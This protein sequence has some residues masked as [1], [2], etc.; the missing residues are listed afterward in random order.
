[1]ISGDAHMLG[2]DDG[3]NNF[4]GEFPVFQVGSLDS[5]PSCKGGPYSHGVY[6]GK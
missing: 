1:M 3:R 2:F 5:I 4:W 6:P